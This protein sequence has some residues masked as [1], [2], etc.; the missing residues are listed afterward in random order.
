MFFG[1]TSRGSG[2]SEILLREF[3]LKPEHRWILSAPELRTALIDIFSGFSNKELRSVLPNL[4][5]L[6]SN[7][8]MSCNVYQYPNRDLILIFPDLLKL[9]RSSQKLLGHAVLMHELGHV[10]HRHCNTEIS[11]LQSQIEADH[12]A[13]KMGYGEELYQVLATEESSS[14]LHSR[15]EELRRLL[16]A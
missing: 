16:I 10:Y 2:N 6:F 8:K 12:F 3:F 15:L 1:L 11:P 7:G 13:W 14:E 5:I 9:L 4:L